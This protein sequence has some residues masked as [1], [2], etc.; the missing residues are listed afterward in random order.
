VIV[1]GS[2][3]SD[4]ALTQTRHVAGLLAAATGIDYRIEVIETTGDRVLERPLAAIGTKGAFTVELEQALRDGRVDAAVHS[5]KDLPVDDPQDLVIGAV[6]ER[7]D[8]ADVLLVRPEAFDAGAAPGSVPLRHGARVGT[9]SPRRGLALQVVRP[10]LRLLDIR[11]NVG[12]RV[13][14]VRSGDYDAAV[15]A[16]AGLDRLRLDVHDLVRWQVPA[17]LLPPA[18]GQGAL[19]VQCRK[20]DR[21][22]RELL[23]AIHDPAAAA[24]VAAERALLAALGGG[25]SLPLGALATVTT[26]GCRIDAALFGGAPAAALRACAEGSDFAAVVAQLA[27]PWQS[28][29]GAPLQGLRIA[30]VRP[31][32]AGGDLAAA[33]AVAGASVEPLALT[34]SIDLPVD[35]QALAAVAAA[36]TLAFASA[37]AVE[38]FG[39][40]LQRSG[41]RPTATTAFAI[42]PTTAAAVL[43]LGLLPAAADGSGGA[44]LAA[45]AAVGLPRGSVL[46]FPCAEGRNPVFEAAAAHAGLVVLP[47]PLYR[48]EANADARL[49]AV[50]PDVVLFTAPSAVAAFRSHRVQFAGTR[51]VAIGPTT[52]AAM[53]GAGLVVDAAASSAAIGPIVTALCEVHHARSS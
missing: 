27:A 53:H 3:S 13:G 43:A 23:G 19:A 16:A 52:A 50:P 21:R 37:R 25:C 14:K 38:L 51:L 34:R 8:P 46:G 11:G 49:P 10:D 7:I 32:G 24:C 20:D 4:L 28:L 47:L 42:G 39:A 30:V 1:F 17:A 36:P 22:V 45:L 9:S 33:L 5:L 40:L 12:T 41:L 29:I 6:P 44:A 26:S 48:I 2:R 35:Q 31:D 15:F 18:P